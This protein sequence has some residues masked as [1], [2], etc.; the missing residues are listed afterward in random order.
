LGDVFPLTFALPQ[1]PKAEECTALKYHH[2]G[3]VANAN[4][5]FEGKLQQIFNAIEQQTSGVV[6]IM[7]A[8]QS[9]SA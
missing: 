8:H 3:S 1:T 7:F 6:S 2:S 4:Q 9:T 5:H